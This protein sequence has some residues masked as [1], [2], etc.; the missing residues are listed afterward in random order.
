M[1]NFP[2]KYFLRMREMN[3]LQSIE[4]IIEENGSVRLLEPVHP[5]R[6]PV[7]VKNQEAK[8]HASRILALLNSSLF[9]NVPP[10]NINEIEAAVRENRNAW[11]D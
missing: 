8:G 9:Q 7:V 11:G 2:E 4:A 1:K 3:M 5:K 10:G 6:E